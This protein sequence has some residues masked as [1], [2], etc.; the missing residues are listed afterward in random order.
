MVLDSKR[1]VNH[2]FGVPIKHLRGKGHARTWTKET[3]KTDTNQS[4]TF[5]LF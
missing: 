1:V 3:V 2:I 4:V 5:F